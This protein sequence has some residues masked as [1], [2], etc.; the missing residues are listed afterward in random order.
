M[1]V[2]DCCAAPVS[3]EADIICSRCKEH[4]EVLNEED[5]DPVMTIRELLKKIDWMKEKVQDLI[6]DLPQNPNI[7]PAGKGFTMSSSNLS[8]ERVLSPEYYDY[9][10][11]YEMINKIIEGT[12]APTLDH[13]I[14]TILKEGR[15][16]NYKLHPDVIESIRIIWEGS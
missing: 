15:I 9:K 14:K 11:Q 12:P 13:R 6:K 2:S 5:L 10:H 4:C 7:K 3:G 16:L 8:K 1:L